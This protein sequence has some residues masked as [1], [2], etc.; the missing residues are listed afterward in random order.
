MR[1]RLGRL[2]SRAPASPGDETVKIRFLIMNAYGMGG[3]IRTTHNTAATLARRGHDVEIVSVYR[4]RNT[5]FLPVDPTVPVR[6]LSDEAPEVRQEPDRNR[7]PVAV[8]RRRVEEMLEARPS[9][10][11]DPEENRYSNFNLLTD[12]RLLRFL[13]SV[14]D[15]VLVSTRPGLNLAVARFGRPE[16]V[17]VGQE[18]LH[19]AHHSRPLRRAIKKHYPSLDVVAPLTERDARDYRRLLGTSTRVIA[20]PNAVPDVGGARAHGDSKVVLAAG[21][22]AVQKGF[23]RLIPAFAAVAAKHPDW[24]LKIFGSGPK[25]AELQRQIDDLGM[26]DRIRLMGYTRNLYGEMAESAIYVMSSRFEGFPMVLLEAMGC[27]LPV[28]SFDFRNGPEDLIEHDVSGLLVPRRDVDALAAALIKLIE[29]PQRRRAFGARGLEIAARYQ[30]D[31]IAA[32]WEQ[33]FRQEL[34]VREAAAGR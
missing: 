22:L 30:I 20:M 17:R 11:I 27:G 26:R 28:V 4:R 5:S 21:R 7:R 3:T 6:A 25:K 9:R 12:A 31:E 14:R 18:H 33:I 13:R 8:A 15:G 2:T 10:L 34:A 16:V 32:R 29:D 1:V 19:L 23:D 24:T